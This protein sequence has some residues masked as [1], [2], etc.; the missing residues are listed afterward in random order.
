MFVALIPMKGRR[1]FPCGNA[2]G[3]AFRILIAVFNRD[4]ASDGGAA[5]D[6]S[7]RLKRP[8]IRRLGRKWQHIERIAA[9]GGHF[10]SLK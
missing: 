5:S 7:G 1:S 10:Y 3:V 2:R 4:V 9:E 6:D 8:T